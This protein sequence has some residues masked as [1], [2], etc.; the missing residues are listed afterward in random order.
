MD[1]SAAEGRQGEG[2]R[3]K[4]TGG[5]IENG[6]SLDPESFYFILK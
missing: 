6:A 2:G 5:E 3:G 4:R 1:I